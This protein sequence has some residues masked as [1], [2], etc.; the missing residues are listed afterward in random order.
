MA[1]PE[2]SP[3]HRTSSEAT[4]DQRCKSGVIP[5]STLQI[6]SYTGPRFAERGKIGVT[7]TGMPSECSKSGIM[8][9]E[10]SIYGAKATYRGQ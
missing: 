3:I 7:V 2:L 6:W 4:P 10:R 1:G 9:S 8:H 5:N